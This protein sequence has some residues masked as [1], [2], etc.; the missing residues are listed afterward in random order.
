MTPLAAFAKAFAI[1][2]GL[3]L[4][5]LAALFLFFVVLAGS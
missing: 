3:T 2:F 4:G 1:A 5:G